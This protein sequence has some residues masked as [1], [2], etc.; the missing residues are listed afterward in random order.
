MKFAVMN[1]FNLIPKRSLELNT[2]TLMI[3]LFLLLHL[4]ENIYI[5]L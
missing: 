1:M 2:N 4:K 3:I 5:Y